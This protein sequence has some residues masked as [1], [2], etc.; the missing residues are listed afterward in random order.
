MKLI[1]ILKINMKIIKCNPIRFFDE[2]MKKFTDSNYRQKSAFR[3]VT[4]ITYPLH[5]R[6]KP[7][8]IPLDYT[9]INTFKRQERMA[10]TTISREGGDL[11]REESERKEEREERRKGGGDMY[12]VSYTGGITNEKKT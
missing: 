3:K 7:N 9:K 10:A 11:W 1:E 5:W 4:T 6:T 12:K 2:S 8:Y